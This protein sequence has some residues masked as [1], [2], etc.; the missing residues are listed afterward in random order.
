VIVTKSDG[1]RTKVVEDSSF[2]VLSGGA[3]GC[4]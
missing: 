1:T 3:T 2:A 4:H